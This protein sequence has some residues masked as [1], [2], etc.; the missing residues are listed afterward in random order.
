MKGIKYLFTVLA[1]LV[2]FT[3]FSQETKMIKNRK[4]MLEKQEEAKEKAQEK[5]RQEGLKRHTK[6]Q[7][8]A[9][10][11]RMKQTAKKNKR[12]HQ[13]KAKKEFFLIRW[14]K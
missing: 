6:I 12:L 7:T 2:S 1:L 9:T 14:F 4:K 13:N 11:K 10:Q 8:K 5:G 3:V